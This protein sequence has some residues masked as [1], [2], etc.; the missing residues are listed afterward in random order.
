MKASRKPGL[1]FQN[2]DLVQP[3]FCTEIWK[4]KLKVFLLSGCVWIPFLTFRDADTQHMLMSFICS[5]A[6]FETSDI[7]AL[8]CCFIK[9]STVKFKW[10]KAWNVVVHGYFIFTRVYILIFFLLF[11][12]ILSYLFQSFFFFYYVCLLVRGFNLFSFFDFV[13]F[14]LFYIFSFFW[15]SVLLFMYFF[16]AFIIFSN[17]FYFCC[18]FFRTSLICHFLLRFAC[19]KNFSGSLLMFYF[20]FLWIYLNLFFFHVNLF[21][22]SHLNS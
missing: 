13:F 4:R 10:V 21:L 8:L 2:I 1:I 18:F 5:C 16:E 19:N 17:V 7:L 15:S 20:L 12:L 9:N 3:L 22:W 11:V 6:R 14:L